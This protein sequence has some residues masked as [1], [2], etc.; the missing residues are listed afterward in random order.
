MEREAGDAE[1]AKHCNRSKSRNPGKRS[2]I[3]SWGHLIQCLWL[4]LLAGVGV[5]DAFA[6]A[7]AAG[8][9]AHL[10]LLLMLLMLLLMLALML[11]FFLLLFAVACGHSHALRARAQR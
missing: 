8:V 6:D 2:K 1:N 7:D 3:I 9:P 10:M 5:A 4:P 11:A